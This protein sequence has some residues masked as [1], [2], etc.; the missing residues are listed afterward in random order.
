MINHKIKK[1]AG[2]DK[3][4]SMSGV[5]GGVGNGGTCGVDFLGI[6]NVTTLHGSGVE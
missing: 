5:R 1:D 3:D 2:N 6:V 4:G